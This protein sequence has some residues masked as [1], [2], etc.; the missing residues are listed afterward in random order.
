MSEYEDIRECCMENI[1]FI[2]NDIIAH[3]N[4]ICDC[5]RKCRV[6]A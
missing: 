3:D 2:Y 6:V 5:G 4:L 1:V